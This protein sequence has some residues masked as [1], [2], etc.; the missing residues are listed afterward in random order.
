MTSLP[1][2]L[3]EFSVIVDAV[4]GFSFKPPSRSP[5]TEILSKVATS[6]IPV[7]SVDI[8]SGWDVEK[9]PS[10]LKDSDPILKP[11][12]LISL[13]APKLCANHFHG[14]FHWVGGRFVP[15]NLQSKYHLV[16][17]PYE[18]EDILFRLK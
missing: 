16:L 17:P 2:S 3:N 14:R 18:G 4:F 11:D 6:G 9:G 5:Y 12:C 7:A 10:E 1:D 8:P 13:T 15:P